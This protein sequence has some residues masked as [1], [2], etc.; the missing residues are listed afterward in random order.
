MTTIRIRATGEVMNERQF[1]AAHHQ[2]SF[3]AVMNWDNQ[4]CDVVFPTPQP[5]CNPLTETVRQLAPA[6]NGLG[7]YEQRWEVVALDA[8]TVAA[9]QA[10]ASRQTAL[11]QIAALEAQVTNRRIREA[12]RGA[13]KAWL[14][15]IDDQI[16]AL[17]SQL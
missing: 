12:I 7:K 13:G 1:R 11:N 2:T 9:N 10:N 14:D 3:P 4:G 6:L 17:R 15:G 16:T 5:A 8:E